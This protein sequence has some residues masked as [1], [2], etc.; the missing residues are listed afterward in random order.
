MRKRYASDT[1]LSFAFA[2]SLVAELIRLKR[3][4][5]KNNTMKLKHQLSVLLLTIL[6]SI[7]AIDSL[8]AEIVIIANP[9][10]DT[11]TLTKKEIKRIFLGRRVKWNDTLQIEIVVLKDPPVYKEFTKKIT[12][13]SVSQFTN[14][15]RKLMFTGKANLPKE[16]ET[17]NELLDYIAK[18]KGAIGYVSSATALEGVKKL[19]ISD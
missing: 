8:R 16:F 18:T 13:K 10:V 3:A 6:F 4:Y 15:W 9:S 7:S 2:Y 1:L 11:N 19:E 14:W 17:E 5:E 12:K